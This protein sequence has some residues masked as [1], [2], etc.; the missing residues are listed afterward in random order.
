MQLRRLGGR[1]QV[2]A[3]RACGSDDAQQR[4]GPLDAL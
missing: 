4:E 2:D 3:F 1:A